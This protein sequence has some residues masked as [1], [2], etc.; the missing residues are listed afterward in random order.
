MVQNLTWSGVYL[1]SNLSSD[2]LQK[3]LKLVLLITTGPKVYFSTMTTA[4]SV[5]CNC[6]VDTLNHT[7]SLKIKD[8]PGENVADFR[9]AIL[10]DDDCLESAGAFKPNNLG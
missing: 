3:V 8:H 6:L 1:R 10:V 9:D 2:L 7:K 5:S 4:L